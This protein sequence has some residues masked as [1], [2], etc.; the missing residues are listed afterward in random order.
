MEKIKITVET[1]VDAT[2][3]KVW[4]F[5]SSPKH[6][7]N[8]YFASSDWHCPK[9]TNSLKVNGSFCFAMAAKDQSFAFDFK[10]V[11]TIVNVNK[12]ICYTMEDGRNCE[13]HFHMNNGQTIISQTFDAEYENSIDMQ[14]FG[15][16]A[17]LN[18]FKNYVESH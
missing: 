15:W 14:R 13:I 1:I 9:A 16:Q 5:W 10:G 2:S 7:V 12:Q 4:D 3:D 18:N 8:W 11:Y 6:I 17:I